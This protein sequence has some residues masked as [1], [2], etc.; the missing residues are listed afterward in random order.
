V[1]RGLFRALCVAQPELGLAAMLYQGG[2]ELLSTHKLQLLAQHGPRSAEGRRALHDIEAEL[3]QLNHQDA[4]QVLDL[5]LK[6]KN[7]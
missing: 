1:L 7:Q 2:S 6:Q 3:Q 4:Q 5:L